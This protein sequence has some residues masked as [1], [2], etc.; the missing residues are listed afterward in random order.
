MTGDLVPYPAYRPSSVEW[1]GDVPAHW[2]V[3]RLKAVCRLAYGDSLPTDA[4]G[5]GRILV[6]GANGPVGTHTTENTMAPA[7][8][9][10]RKGSFG[11]VH[12]SKQA[13]FAIDTTYYVDARH[14]M[15]HLRWLY[16][17]LGWLQLDAVTRDS[18]VPGLNRED[19][20]GRELALPSLPEQTAIVRYLDHVDRSIR[21][22]VSAK[23]R[24]VALLEE[25][26]QAVINQAATRGLDPNVRL[27]PSGVEWLGD[28]PE[29]WDVTALRNKWAARWTKILG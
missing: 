14:C 1:L 26:K 2:K 13:V 27:K 22:Y 18:A 24:L 28:V 11:K 3:R 15:L 19:A 16:W 25:E 21:R 20:Y 17:V 8:V 6:Y 10:G 23:R 29:H 12:F 4:R 5:D 7:I 9:I